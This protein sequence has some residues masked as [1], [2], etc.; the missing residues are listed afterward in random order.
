MAC[1]A[2]DIPRLSFPRNEIIEII[3]ASYNNEAKRILIP[4]LPM[5]TIPGSPEDLQIPVA[6]SLPP[7]GKITP[8]SLNSV[9]GG[10]GTPRIA[11]GPSKSGVW[12]PQEPGTGSQLLV[13]RA[14]RD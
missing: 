3:P 1:N 9:E 8:M 4:D 6:P 14:L 11:I 13:E 10:A 7:S 2:T 12:T 5:E